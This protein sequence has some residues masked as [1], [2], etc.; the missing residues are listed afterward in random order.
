M[1]EIETD[2]HYVRTVN[3]S[4]RLNATRSRANSDLQAVRY[5]SFVSHLK[6]IASHY[7]LQLSSNSVPPEGL[8]NV[9]A[10]RLTAECF[11]VQIIFNRISSVPRHPVPF[12]SSSGSQDLVTFSAV[13]FEYNHDKPVP[14]QELSDDLNLGRFESLSEHIRNL[15]TIYSIPGNET[16][17]A[18]AYLCLQ[19]IEKDVSVLSQA[20]RL[21]LPDSQRCVGE[22]PVASKHTQTEKKDAFFMQ[23]LVN[24]SL[25]GYF[26]PRSGGRLA[27][28]TYLVTNAQ[29]AITKYLQLPTDASRFTSRSGRISTVGRGSPDAVVGGF[30]ARVGVQPRSD[31]GNKYEL[32]RRPLQHLPYIPLVTL[33][34][35]S[36]GISIPE[37]S[38]PDEL[39]CLLIEA[40]FVLYLDPP[41]PMPTETVRRL[42]QITGIPNADVVGKQEEDIVYLIL[43]RHGQNHLFGIDT[44]M[45]LP[46]LTQ[47]SY[48]VKSRLRGYMISKIPFACSSQ[49][50]EIISILRQQASA[51]SFYETFVLHPQKPVE[52]DD[53]LTFSFGIQ[54]VSSR[55]IEVQFDHPCDISRNVHLSVTIGQFGVEQAVVNGTR[56]EEIDLSTHFSPN[57]Q[58]LPES[59]ED[60]PDPTE[61]F[62]R[63]HAL[64]VGLAWLL[65][66]LGCPVHRRLMSTRQFMM[67]SNGYNKLTDSIDAPNSISVRLKTLTGLRHLDHLRDMLGRARSH[68][69]IQGVTGT[70]GVLSGADRF[71][72]L[73]LDIPRV[74][75][76]T[77]MVPTTIPSALKMAALPPGVLATPPPAGSH[78]DVNPND[79]AMGVAGA[80]RSADF[81][82]KHRAAYGMTPTPPAAA[83][84]S[85]SRPSRLDD[86]LIDNMFPQCFSASLGT[87]VS[88][89]GSSVTSF[90]SPA[91]QSKPGA[92]LRE[93]NSEYSSSS[94]VAG[95]SIGSNTAGPSSSQTAAYMSPRSLLNPAP[96]SNL[97]VSSSVPIHETP[98]LASTPAIC[99]PG[100]FAQN[101]PTINQVA[102]SKTLGN[103]P[104]S[105]GKG[106]NCG[107]M[108]VNLLNEEP[109]APSVTP[110]A[111]QLNHS[112]SSQRV[113]IP[114]FSSGSLLSRAAESHT[115]VSNVTS[116]RYSPSVPVSFTPTVLTNVTSPS[117]SGPGRPHLNSSAVN[118]PTTSVVAET[119]F[120]THNV[121]KSS[122]ALQSGRNP[123]PAAKIKSSSVNL[124]SS[125]NSNSPSVS[126]APKKARKRRRG[127]TDGGYVSTPTFKPNSSVGPALQ[128]SPQPAAKHQRTEPITGMHNSFHRASFPP[129]SSSFGLP[130]SSAIPSSFITTSGSNPGSHLTSSHVTGKSVYDFDDTPGS[131]F[132]VTIPSI[133]S[134][135]SSSSYQNLSLTPNS[136]LAA[137]NYSSSTPSSLGSSI[138]SS[139]QLAATPMASVVNTVPTSGTFIP[140]R[141]VER[142]T[143]LKMTIKTLPPQ[144]SS[145][146]PRSANLSP[147][148]ISVSRIASPK[149]SP[150]AVLKQSDGQTVSPVKKRKRRSVDGKPSSY[151]LQMLQHPSSSSV[152]ASQ[153][154][155]GIKMPKTGTS[156]G[157]GGS[158]VKKERKR[159]LGCTIADKTQHLP[160]SSVG[161]AGSSSIS[162]APTKEVRKTGKIGRPRIVGT[163]KYKSKAKGAALSEVHIISS[164]TPTGT[165]SYEV[166]SVKKKSSMGHV[167][168]SHGLNSDDGNIGRKQHTAT[169]FS[170]AGGSDHKRKK[171]MDSSRYQGPAFPSYAFDASQADPD[172]PISMPTSSSNPD[173]YSANSTGSKLSRTTSASSMS[174]PGR[175]SFHSSFSSTLKGQSA[176]SSGQHSTAASGLMNV[177]P[178]VGSGGLIKGYK[179]PKKKPLASVVSDP[180][181]YASIERTVQPSQLNSSVITD[182]DCRDSKKFDESFVNEDNS[183]SGN[184]SNPIL[185]QSFHTSAEAGEL[186]PL[187]PSTG[188]HQASA[189]STSCSSLTQP[190]SIGSGLVNTS[191]HQPRRPSVKSIS[192]IVDKLRAKSSVNCSVGNSSSNNPSS[193]NQP[194]NQNSELQPPEIDRNRLNTVPRETAGTV[195]AESNVQSQEQRGDNIFEKFYPSTP[196]SNCHIESSGSIKP[197]PSSQTMDPLL[198]PSSRS[199]FSDC[200]DGKPRA[201]DSNV[202]LVDDHSVSAN[203][204]GSS[205]HYHEEDQSGDDGNKL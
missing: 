177:N 121:P 94:P 25:V 182:S 205:G 142:K 125:A 56:G 11:S 163:E 16:T 159:R 44:H 59:E 100:T 167:P 37:F 24:R 136:K 29:A 9:G 88:E 154:S 8:S 2:Q 33:Q 130:S 35:G 129:S 168:F 92:N 86:L 186:T 145:S 93:L 48:A 115:V 137:P 22:F 139:E 150:D 52:K 15:L 72:A 127:T 176:P 156:L 104:S 90:I 20:M 155:A 132:D 36:N 194:S 158:L 191:S 187:V 157:H 32:G 179:I 172:D 189:D 149:A 91:A 68:V 152:H 164:G 117:S 204:T 5:T 161:I 95:F 171:G 80:L 74:Q 200:E 50:A 18:Q 131:L 75:H 46:N 98:V 134:S 21:N 122:V 69:I 54:I 102:G 109:V 193:M 89:F 135:A 197:T 140:E 6:R 201:E 174:G 101:S 184:G 65:T 49:L 67:G 143:S 7:G 106:S 73:D 57:G 12:A 84:N 178:S 113:Q 39:K 77:P 71:A 128:S 66:N 123:L 10:W 119:G 38:Q 170:A 151:M 162:V 148:K 64:P 58:L 103:T 173:L 165:I 62:S 138:A 141:T 192:D 108:L 195:D 17:R 120:L 202:Q 55:Q 60:A 82:A 175:G 114:S 133:A 23:K 96:S 40:E 169:A 19:A 110:V 183:A 153:S 14:C 160:S 144:S 30:L 31:Y 126:V 27:R 112:S 61:I 146:V 3:I 53:A 28:L 34:E 13:R 42:E 41:L 97:S 1:G 199:A 198:S 111:S 196:N 124:S 118:P 78:L 43:S 4:S 203:S 47:H 81:Q 166:A 188:L 99:I 70:G 116:N 26:C 147:S 79:P 107:S 87:S 190:V 105:T 63:S 185:V 83:P 180:P 51:V 85:N 181:H 45:Q 76:I